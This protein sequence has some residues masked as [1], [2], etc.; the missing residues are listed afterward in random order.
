[1]NA[2]Y[3]TAKSSET[4]LRQS[5][6]ALTEQLHQKEQRISQLQAKLQEALDALPKSPQEP[7]V[8]H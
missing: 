2:C 7:Q 1:M 3:E 6:I 8:Q 5:N 4:Q